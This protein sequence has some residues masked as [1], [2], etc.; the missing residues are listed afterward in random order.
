MEVEEKD[1]KKKRRNH[2]EAYKGHLT[3]CEGNLDRTL[4]REEQSIGGANGG[5]HTEEGSTEESKHGFI[6]CF[7]VLLMRCSHDIFMT[8]FF[9]RSEIPPL[10]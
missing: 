9:V 8:D 1:E 5:Q 3:I 7:C 6:E 4:W 10:P 2:N